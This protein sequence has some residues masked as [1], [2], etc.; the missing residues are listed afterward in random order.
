MSFEGRYTEGER[1]QAVAY[2]VSLIINGGLNR[3]AAGDMVHEHLGPSRATV[4]RW[5]EED[6]A[7]L[8]PTFADLQK[9]RDR[10]TALEKTVA[11]LRQEND[12]LKARLKGSAV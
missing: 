4:A 5:A 11:E 2:Y 1:Q 12:L 9:A 7:L 10:A 3:R 6:D 8:P